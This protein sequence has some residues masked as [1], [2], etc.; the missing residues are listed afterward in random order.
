MLSGI[1]EDVVTETFEEVLEC[2][3]PK[4]HT[5]QD[6]PFLFVMAKIW[7]TRKSTVTHTNI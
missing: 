2:I 5:T 7:E 6:G 3:V 1:L 4:N